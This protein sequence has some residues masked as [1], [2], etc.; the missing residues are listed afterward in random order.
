MQDP[1]NS[2]AHSPAHGLHHSLC[3]HNSNDGA[4][5]SSST[6]TKDPVCGMT[7]VTEK[8]AAR[9]TVDGK[10]YYFCSERCRTKF[11]ANPAGYLSSKGAVTI[12]STE[13]VGAVTYTCPMHPEI[14]Q[15]GPGSCPI[16]GMALEPV[17]PSIEVEN[18]ELRDMSRRFKV[19]AALT[20][21]LLLLT[22]GEMIPVLSN[23]ITRLGAANRWI[24]FL[25]STPVVLWAGWP[26]FVK[27]YQS[28]KTCHLNM[29][30][31]IAMGTGV[32]YLYSLV[33]LFIPDIFPHMLRG[34]SGMVGVYFEAAAVIVTLV[35][36]GQVLELKARSQ[37]SSAIKSLLGLVPKT[38]RRIKNGSEVDVPLDQ[39][40]VGDNLRV[41][42]GE[43][44]PVDGVVVDGKT[45]IDESM[46]T[47]E[48]MP[49]QKAPGD[50]VTAGTINSTG[51]VIMEARRVGSDTLLAQIVKLVSEAQRSRAPIQRLADQVSGYFVPAVIV[52]AILTALIWGF[53]GV[54]PKL[55]YAVVNAVAVLIIAC[56][57]AL[58]LATPMSIMVGTGRG[59]E[60]GVLIKNA[61]ALE[62]FEKVDTLVLDKT[63]TLTEGRPRLVAVVPLEGV[64]EAD[65][66]RLSA[67]LEAASEHPLAEAIVKGAREKGVA[68][69]AV[70]KDLSKN[71]L[72]TSRR[73]SVV[74]FPMK[75]MPFYI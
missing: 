63:G 67:G 45:N 73:N 71:N 36:L 48:P 20:L 55:A 37:T 40:E 49:V 5:A 17:D 61:Q 9:F 60:L 41:R 21:P 75:C 44:V 10:E 1:K 65:L 52:I 57:C 56:P 64:A 74:P 22:M 72:D 53:F 42:P 7:V 62:V 23:Q 31:L 46:I 18:P 35:L 6:T 24:Q 2:P 51:S 54:E 30:S 8:A 13:Q 19:G 70:S 50:F 11:V 16:C 26:F 47:G 58:G 32:A 39:V 25:L 38:A 69:E 68:V 59:A 15:V 34:P 28:F 33:A 66:L 4:L 12:V 27:G 3:K 43:K 14:R 29:F